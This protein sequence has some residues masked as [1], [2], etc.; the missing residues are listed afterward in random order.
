MDGSSQGWFPAA[1]SPALPALGPR[2][3]GSREQ[4]AP[5]RHL[6]CGILVLVV[7]SAASLNVMLNLEQ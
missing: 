6:P 2:G 5:A 3:Q 7:W 4:P 1:P